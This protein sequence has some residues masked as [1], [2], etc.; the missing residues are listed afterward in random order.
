[1]ASEAI[2]RLLAARERWI[3][4]EDSKDVKV[5]RPAEIRMLDFMQSGSPEKFAG[6]VVDWRGFTEASIFGASVASDSPMP[7]DA[8]LWQEL[9]LDNAKW[10]AKVA[11][12]VREDCSQHLQAREEAAKN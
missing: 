12:A 8:D 4:L 10:L 6:C 1:M 7:F 5:R 3:T 11:E 2:K 9:A